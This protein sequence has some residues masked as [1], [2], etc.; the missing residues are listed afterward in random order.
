[1][2]QIAKTLGLANPKK[3]TEAQ[4]I[5]AIAEM[6][7]T[8][9]ATAASLADAQTHIKATA[10]HTNELN[11]TIN[12]LKAEKQALTEKCLVLAEHN[13]ADV[14]TADQTI[15][16]DEAIEKAKATL[17]ASDVKEGYP[18]TDGTLFYNESAAV[19]YALRHNLRVLPKISL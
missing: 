4:I 11:E 10:N 3:A 13:D 6:V 18:V 15:S 12:A 1:M 9:K 16:E 14:H 19:E 8:S 17:I 7:E 2:E 5:N